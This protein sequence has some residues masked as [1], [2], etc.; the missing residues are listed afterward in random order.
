MLLLLNEYYKKLIVDGL[1]QRTAELHIAY[2]RYFAN[3]YESEN[4]KEVSPADIE[5]YKIYLMT[6]HKTRFSKRSL[7]GA[8]IAARLWI[9]KSYFKFLQEFRQI[10]FNPTTGLT[11]PKVRRSRRIDLVSEKEMQELILKPDTTTL[12][13]IR[14]RLIFEF[15]YTTSLRCAEICYLKLSDVDMKERY[16]YPSTTK[17]GRECTIPIPPSIF[18]TLEKYIT[19]VRPQIVKQSGKPDIPE[20]LITRYGEC[21]T[22]HSMNQLCRIYRGPGTDKMHIHPHAIRHSYVVGLFKNGADQG[23]KGIGY[24]SPPE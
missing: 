12:L 11:V 3:W 7:T 19:D 14:D 21:L 23:E 10:A 9:L 17:D 5:R 2:C 1:S 4:M 16:I 8:S 18:Q 6:E 20:L 13:G 24:A 22:A 15:F